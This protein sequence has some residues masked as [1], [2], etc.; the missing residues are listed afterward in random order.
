MEIFITIVQFLAAL[1]IGF[2]LIKFALNFKDS[3]K[4]SK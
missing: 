3:I 1:A 4:N 2:F